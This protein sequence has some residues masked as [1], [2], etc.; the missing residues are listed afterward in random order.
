MS[1]ESI[2][3]KAVFDLY[4]SLSN[5]DQREFLRL[6]GR[7]AVAESPFVIAREL[8]LSELKRF[9][10]MIHQE[11]AW[12]SFPVFIQEA[13]RLAREQP[14]ISDEE[15]DKL[16]NEQVSGR[17]V[18]YDQK[19]SELERAKLKEQ[20]DRK[21]DPETVRRN[22]EICDLRNENPHK[23]SQGRLARQ[24]DVTPRAIRKILAD[25]VK[26]RRLSAEKRTN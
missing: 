18:D 26:W 19:I 7:S 17:M 13:R 14:Q 10:Q 22:L 23:W 2:T 3:P 15:F 11:L 24:F 1:I 5:E 8:P 25:E 16:L 6:L 9:S 4:I 21:S 20:R 12:Q